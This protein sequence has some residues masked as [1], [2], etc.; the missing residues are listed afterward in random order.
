MFVLKS[1]A[2]NKDS[3]PEIILNSKKAISTTDE[4]VP[5]FQLRK[6]ILS[7]LNSNSVA[8][9]LKFIPGVL[10]KDYGG[11]GGLKTV[12]IRSLGANHTGVLYDGLS[13]SNS[14][15]G[16]ID[17]G[18]ISLDNI[19]SLTLY[20]SQPLTILMPARS[21]A[22]AS[23][24]S[25]NSQSQNIDS[26]KKISGDA[27]VN[28]GSF[29]L[30]STSASIKKS[31]AKNWFTSISANLQKSSGNYSFKSYVNIN[32][33]LKRE[34]TD[35]NSFR[36]E[37]NLA[38]L[39][40]NDDKIKLKAYYYQSN[41]GLPGSVIYFNN[42]SNQR[43]FE[44]NAF[45]Q[46]SWKITISKKSKLLFS[47]KLSYDLSDYT[48]P[49]FQ[50]SM[51]GIQNTFH[52]KEAYASSAYSYKISKRLT[53]AYAADIF[54]TN[55][56]RTDKFSNDFQDPSRLTF[57][58][59]LSFYADYNALKIS[60][61]LLS[62]YFKDY[63][64]NEIEKVS[65]SEVSPA[66]SAIWQ[67]V[68]KLPLKIRAFYKNIFRAP[69]FNDLYY[70][71]VGN[72]NLKPE[73]INEFNSGITFNPSLKQFKNLEFSVDGYLNKIHDKIIAVPRQNLF[74]WTMLNIGEVEIHGIDISTRF[75]LKEINKINISGMVSYTYQQAL[76][77]SNKNSNI[78]KTQLPYVPKH[79]G[80]AHLNAEIKRFSFSYNILFSGDRYRLG[81]PVIDN[82]VAGFGIQ[83]FSM[84][85]YSFFKGH[86]YV[87]TSMLNNISNNNYEVIKYYPMPGFNYRLC[88]TVSL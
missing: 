13:I 7:N 78:Y 15:S 44:R 85:F 87:I 46:G 72:T 47:G 32:E 21:F 3:L 80:S 5:I 9:A 28:F 70:T 43:L 42:I 55:L 81:E 68:E 75:Y 50:N 88:L 35:L 71:N 8:D 54:I 51:G 12:S 59:N 52:Q 16:I 64:K 65:A 18:K 27:S 39:K 22:S 48:D 34:N 2:Q 40:L 57:L 23:I 1:E 82:R 56:K 63:L 4:T 37:L 24:I 74:Q 69:T 20:Q 49:D 25:I 36:F 17:L 11:I 77:V 26:S 66:I 79:S 30:L 53:G 86:K 10:V 33:T 62:T 41:R 83:D 6:K 14:S 84:S 19:E 76:D 45:F 73:Y 29:G 58:N 31:L 38:K 61:N 60:G 67:P